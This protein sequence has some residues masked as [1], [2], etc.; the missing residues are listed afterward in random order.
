MERTFL[1]GICLLAPGLK[2]S[3]NRKYEK[4]S[5]TETLAYIAAVIIGLFVNVNLKLTPCDNAILTP[6]VI[7]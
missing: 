5:L 2:W 3:P 7:I 6:L 1:E 4:T